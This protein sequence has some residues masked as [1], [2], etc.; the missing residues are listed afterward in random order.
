MHSV[1]PQPSPTPHRHGCEHFDKSRCRTLLPGYRR[2]GNP[3]TPYSNYGSLGHYVINGSVVSATLRA[4]FTYTTSAL[5]AAFTDLSTDSAGTIT[6]WDWSFG[7]GGSSTVQHP[8]HSYAAGGSY[9]VTLTV[10]DSA[11]SSAETSRIVTVTQPMPPPLPASP[12]ARQAL[13]SL[14]PTPPPTVMGQSPPGSGISAT[15]A[16]PYHGIQRTPMLPAAITRS[17]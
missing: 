12:T 13:P 9:T 1:W 11:G 6:S 5:Q 16:R 14:S 10:V 2:V 7:D 8:A 3:V 15:A 17:R 4:D